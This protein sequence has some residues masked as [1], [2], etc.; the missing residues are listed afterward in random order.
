MWTFVLALSPALVTAQDKSSAVLPHGAVA[1]PHNAPADSPNELA[2]SDLSGW[3]DSVVTNR[4]QRSDVAGAVI[5]VVKDGNVL[6][7]KSYGYA[8]VAAQRPIDPQTTLFRVA[9]ISKL[10]TFTAVMQQVELGKL[11]LDAD[12]NTY[13][14]FKIPEAWPNPITLR[15]LMTHTAGFEEANKNTYAADIESMPALG[16]LLKSWVPERVYPPGE[17]V[18]YSNYGAALAGYIV[19]RVTNERFEDYVAQHIL[20]PLGMKHSTFVQ[21]V[22]PP[23]AEDLS[24]GYVLNTDAPSP[25]ELVE[26]RPA[27]GLSASGADVARFMIAH[28][29]NGAFEGG[30]ILEPQT[31]TL[32]HAEAYR[33][34]PLLPGMGLG[35]W[36]LDRSGHVVVAHTGDT[37]VFHSGLYLILDAN[38]GL[39]VAANSKGTDDDFSRKLFESFMDRYFSAPQT[40]SEPA[41]ETA[42]TDGRLVAGIYEN[43]RRADSS[44]MIA[45]EL[46]NERTILVNPDAT[47]SLSG[48]RDASGEL[49]RWREVVPFRWREVDGAHILDAQIKDGHVASIVTNVGAPTSIL[50]PVPFLRSAVWNVP[51]FL[52]T[53]G[54]LALAVL[55][56]PIVAIVRRLF[57]RPFP[58]VGRE[59]IAYRLA[60]IIVIVDLVF[61]CGWVAFL[62]Y[63]DSNVQA[64]DSRIDWVLRALQMIG[65]LGV[66][67]AAVPIYVL[68]RALHNPKLRWWAKASDALIACACTTMVWF[69]FSL[70]LLPWTLN[71]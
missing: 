56:W 6:C 5:V 41:L 11:D 32:M 43:S 37:S 42:R 52:A 15:N 48:S 18:A 25:F 14:D 47:I 54:V 23:L 69:A 70:K 62:S 45:E 38:T 7:A 26:L 55:L 64:M 20:A 65:T 66:F 2:A 63:T 3:L 31:A 57:H 36:H 19:E 44:F 21:P 29:N 50:M 58:R 28:L 40:A 53:L 16:A 46:A 30:R 71:Y 1:V 51:L 49:R 34:D 61:L 22:P 60:R 8:D 35:F 59:A 10:F 4:M 13:L 17:V 12:I 68:V 39:F 9:S 27:G 33:P 24:N 67:G